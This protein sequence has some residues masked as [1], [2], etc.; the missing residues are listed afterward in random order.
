MKRTVFSIGV[1]LCLVTGTALNSASL[2]AQ[3]REGQRN[4]ATKTRTLG[5]SDQRFVQAAERYLIRKL[6]GR[7]FKKYL[8][9]EAGNPYGDSIGDTYTVRNEISF[10]YAIPF[11][12]AA[13]A[14]P[15]QP[16]RV[17]VT[18]DTGAYVLAYT[19]PVK[20][21]RFRVSKEAAIKNAGSH[22]LAKIT[23]AG[24]AATA[25]TQKGYELVWAVSSEDVLEQGR[26]AGEAIYKGIYVDID[27][28][29]IR[30]EYKINP[31]I[32]APAGITRV[33]LNEY[34]DKQQ[35]H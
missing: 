13:D 3:A 15:G 24:I 17:T 16:L 28:G 8:R 6:G 21:Y 26:V 18:L 25:G 22:G 9:F 4:P 20:P 7:Y 35:R 12:T 33:K 34:F 31:L 2:Q 5:S 32:L 11:E 30:G 29:K 14:P 23:G 10:G 19:G 1:A 27:T